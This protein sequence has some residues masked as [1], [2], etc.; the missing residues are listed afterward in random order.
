MTIALQSL[1]AMICQK[2]S[3]KQEEEALLI[4]KE[5]PRKFLHSACITGN[6]KAMTEW[7]RT[8]QYGSSLLLNQLH[9]LQLAQPSAFGSNL[10]D[11]LMRFINFLNKDFHPHFDYDQCM[12]QPLWLTA[13]EKIGVQLQSLKQALNAASVAGLVDLLEM[14]YYKNTTLGSFSFAHSSYW[15]RLLEVL[16]NPPNT[17]DLV[18]HYNHT[19]IQYNFNSP[20]FIQHFLNQLDQGLED[21]L[22]THYHWSCQLRQI[23]RIQ[24]LFHHSLYPKRPS[25]KKVLLAHIQLEIDSIKKISG[26]ASLNPENKDKENVPIGL[27]FTS[28][29]LG[30]ITRLLVDNKTLPAPNQTEL[31]RLIARSF[32]LKGNKPVTTETLR[33]KYYTMDPNGLRGARAFFV[34]MLHSLPKYY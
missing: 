24:S 6:K 23:N 31:L 20:Y 7:V 21:E 34:K 8:A 12:P 9:E 25:C 19:L 18:T 16:A 4:A 3:P 26:Q 15:A 28:A 30:A 13:G 10:Q 33:V 22:E 11:L 1:H 5:L 17:S 27:P 14:E 29:E 2:L 32:L